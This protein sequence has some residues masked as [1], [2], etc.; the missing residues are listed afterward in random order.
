LKKEGITAHIVLKNPKNENY[1]RAS[2]LCIESYD[3]I[4]KFLREIYPYSIIK[5]E[6]I[7]LMNKF[8]QIRENLPILKRGTKIDNLRRKHWTKKL[9]LKAM[10]IRDKLKNT[11][12]RKEI[13]HKYNFEYFQKLWSNI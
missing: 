3:G 11:K 9:F 4:K 13:K 7:N 12:F 6:Q 10:K 8:F 2:Y 1:Q 5:K